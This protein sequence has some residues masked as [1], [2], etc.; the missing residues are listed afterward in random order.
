[1]KRPWVF[2][3]LELLKDVL[4]L[5][6]V[7]QTVLKC[8]VRR[9]GLRKSVMSLPCPSDPPRAHQHHAEEAGEAHRHQR[10]RTRLGVRSA[11][12]RFAA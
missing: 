9:R 5:I 2:L 7:L 4:A 3:L 6:R 12:A 8:N 11:P 1:M 10:Q